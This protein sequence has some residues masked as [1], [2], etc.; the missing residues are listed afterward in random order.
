MEVA[1]HKARVEELEGFIASKR[2]EL[3][4]VKEQLA[5]NARARRWIKILTEVRDE[6]V[7]RDRLPR[8]V[9]KNYLLDMVDSINDTLAEFNAPIPRD[10]Q[11]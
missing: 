3:E 7:H 11:R 9:H 6:V 5:R 4:Q 8:V 10:R 1:G 2:E